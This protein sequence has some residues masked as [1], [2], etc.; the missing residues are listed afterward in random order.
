M[1][2]EKSGG[3]P[4]PEK[5]VVEKNP[6]L[7][8]LFGKPKTGK[9]TIVSQLENSLLIELEQGGADFV[10][11]SVVQVDSLNK[12]KEVGVKIKE[13]GKPYK[14]VVIDTVTKLEELVLPYAAQL[15]KQ[16]PMGKNWT[17]RDVK[18][19]PK[20]AGY[21]YLRKAFF[22]V[23]DE[24]QSWAEYVVLVGHLKDNLIEK[25][26]Q[27]FTS[28]E[29]DLTGKIKSLLSAQSDAI[30]YFFRKGPEGFLNFEPTEDTVAGCRSPHLEGQILK[31][32]EKKEGKVVTNWKAIFKF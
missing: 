30:A 26:G 31:I 21:Y 17:G 7:F 20:G 19:L 1:A 25:E 23:I 29:L 27:E 6:K 8:I 15:Y 14:Y 9:T 10:G 12:L 28:M 11:G 2:N 13:Y 4:F 5:K 18:T 24:I 16:T 32:S 22:S 3:L